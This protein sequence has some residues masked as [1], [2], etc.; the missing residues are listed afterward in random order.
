MLGTVLDNLTLRV[1][2]FVFWALLAFGPMFLFVRAVDKL[3]E[4]VSRLLNSNT[5]TSVSVVS[6]KLIL[7][8][9]AAWALVMLLPAL[10]VTTLAIHGPP[11]GQDI[12]VFLIESLRRWVFVV[13]FVAAFG[14]SSVVVVALIG[15]RGEQP[16]FI[17]IVGAFALLL[18]V[19]SFFY[20]LFG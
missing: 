1:L 2:F 5:Q 14:I 18:F 10:I 13:A 4:T 19:S 12:V 7:S 11:E 8:I 3:E 15:D 17:P 6:R 9:C 16:I 20:F